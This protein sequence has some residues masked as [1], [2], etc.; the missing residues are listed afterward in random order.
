LPDNPFERLA[1]ESIGE[2]LGLA[3]PRLLGALA[4]ARP[5][6]LVVEDL[7]CAEPTLLDMVEHLVARSTGPAL[8]VATAR[9]ELAELRPNCSSR[10]GVSQSR[11]DAVRGGSCAAG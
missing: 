10:P 6:L 11:L 7:H 2:E 9:S 3:W 4:A 8:I 1:P 5:T